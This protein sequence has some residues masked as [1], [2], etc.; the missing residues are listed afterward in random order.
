MRFRWEEDE[1]TKNFFEMTI[2]IDDITEDLALNITDFCEEG[3]EEEN[4]NVLGK[5]YR[6]P[7]NK[8]RCGIILGLYEM[9][10]LMN[11]LSFI[12][13][14]NKS[15]QKLENQYF[16]S[17]ELSVKNRAFLWGDS[18]KVSFFVRNGG[19]IMDE[20]CYFFL[21][22]SMRKMRLN[23][24]LTYTP[25]VFPEPFSKKKSLKVKESRTELSISVCSEIM[26]E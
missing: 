7:E 16:T 11:D 3:D 20:E 14:V 19:L 18:V 13:F 2:T 1:G 25:G 6:K 12:I 21:M 24:P 17:D 10:K 26:M 8:T 22:A 23:I 5:S 4:A 9:I 15:Y